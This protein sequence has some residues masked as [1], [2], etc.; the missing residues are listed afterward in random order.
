[1][2][3]SF[4]LGGGVVL[5][6][7]MGSVTTSELAVSFRSFS[8]TGAGSEVLI[9]CVANTVCRVVFSPASSIGV[10]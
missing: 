3:S 4:V 8:M 1:M 2:G 9:A 5:T 6:I 7:G 10:V